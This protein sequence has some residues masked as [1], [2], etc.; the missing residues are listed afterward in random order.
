MREI[1]FVMTKF[2]RAFSLLEILLAVGLLAILSFA[3]FRSW[4]TA[5][6]RGNSIRIWLQIE[7]T[8]DAAYRWMYNNPYKYE[9][10]SLKTVCDNGYLGGEF[11]SNDSSSE[12]Y[13]LDYLKVSKSIGLEVEPL[14]EPVCLEL[15]GR[16]K[17]SGYTVGCGPT[18]E[19]LSI[20]HAF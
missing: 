15:F 20:S 1:R 3:V 14:S 11:C 18:N 16:L 4:E 6:N 17:K 2:Q 10:L 12:K 5:Q 8:F 13:V 7:A 19:K 9:E